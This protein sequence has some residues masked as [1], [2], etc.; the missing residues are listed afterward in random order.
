MSR[1]AEVGF[2]LLIGACLA[3]GAVMQVGEAVVDVNTK[4]QAEPP[5]QPLEAPPPATPLIG[6]PGDAA[7]IGKAAAMSDQIDHYTG[8]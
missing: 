2:A 3:L 8:W 1:L 7:A 6:A 5:V 4:P